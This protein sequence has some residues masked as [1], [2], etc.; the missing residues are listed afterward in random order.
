MKKR[1]ILTVVFAFVLALT[2]MTSSFAAVQ[3]EF[4]QTFEGTNI[5]ITG[6]GEMIYVN[7]TVISV[8]L[9]TNNAFNFFLDPMG[10]LGLA[11]GAV[12]EGAEHE[13]AKGLIH[14]PRT[15]AIIN[16]SSV[17]ITVTAGIR[18][19]GTNNFTHMTFPTTNV[20]GNMPAN[21]G[22][23]SNGSATAPTFFDTNRLLSPENMLHMIKGGTV[24]ADV[25][26]THSGHTFE[27]ANRIAMYAEFSQDSIHSPVGCLVANDGSYC[28]GTDVD[29]FIAE[30]IVFKSSGVAYML[31]N[32]AINFRFILEPA[33]FDVVISGSVI[34]NDLHVQYNRITDTSNGTAIKLGG[35]INPNADWSNF[36]SVAAHIPVG[37][38]QWAPFDPVN[39]ALQVRNEHNQILYT[40]SPANRVQLPFG[41]TPD[42]LVPVAA[43]DFTSTNSAILNGY[44]LISTGATSLFLDAFTNQVVRGGTLGNPTTRL[45]KVGNTALDINAS[46]FTGTNDAARLQ[47]AVLA[48]INNGTIF[49]LPAAHNSNLENI[50]FRAFQENPHIGRIGVEATFRFIV[51]TSD[52]QI[53]AARPFGRPVGQGGTGNNT[54]DGF[55]NDTNGDP[56][57]YGL[58]GHSVNGT[59]IRVIAAPSEF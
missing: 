19:T 28:D 22:S 33:D 29:C 18:V 32:T 20:S 26:R 6:D 48:N 50:Y 51:S 4:D 41:V 17:P 8:T 54:A 57:P 40:L 2:L 3:G 58:M 7:T 31:G 37:N 1:K 15:P 35:F 34:T 5:I 49:A 13:A 30:C 59:A 11:S 46:A 42:M 47:A 14:F 25:S 16:N 53:A 27:T 24:S 56:G 55:A 52:D 43:S 10:L 45:W 23:M 9:P 39:D 21:R 36:M 12:W 44:A 38:N